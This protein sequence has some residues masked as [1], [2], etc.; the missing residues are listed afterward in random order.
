[1]KLRNYIRNQIIYKVPEHGE[2]EP[3]LLYNSRTQEKVPKIIIHEKTSTKKL[4]QGT[5]IQTYVI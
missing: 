2:R 5:Q 1:M 4:I 3:Q